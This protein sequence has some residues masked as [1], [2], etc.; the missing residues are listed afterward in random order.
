MTATTSRD[1]K[2]FL[3]KPD[4]ECI[5]AGDVNLGSQPSVQK[6][7]DAVK[8]RG[9]SY[10]IYGKG[11]KSEKCWMENVVWLEA[12]HWE[13]DDYDFYALEDESTCADPSIEDPES[14]QCNCAENMER[15]C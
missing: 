14:W 7:A 3:V 11:Y 5:T 4:V 10:F 1:V 12:C 15:V 9:G 8:A 13:H 2:Y 6:C